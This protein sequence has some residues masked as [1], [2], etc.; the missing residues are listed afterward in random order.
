LTNT[1]Q[2]D[3]LFEKKIMVSKNIVHEV[4]IDDQLNEKLHSIQTIENLNLNNN[5]ICHEL[6]NL[7][8]NQKLI[9]DE[10]QNSQVNQL[11]QGDDQQNIIKPELYLQNKQQQILQNKNLEKGMQILMNFKKQ[12]NISFIC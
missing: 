11:N 10:L 5:L 3:A 7:N 6:Q 12:T 1:L 2:D 4:T 8:P 9:S